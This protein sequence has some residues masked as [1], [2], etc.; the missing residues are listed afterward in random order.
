MW[1]TTGWLDGHY[2]HR[3]PPP[4]LRPMILPSRCLAVR[5][6]DFGLEA[7]RAVFTALAAA[8]GRGR[9]DNRKVTGYSSEGRHNMSCILSELY[10]V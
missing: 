3:P 10:T 9:G 2:F 5:G 6:L 7:A 4:L 8:E 1:Y